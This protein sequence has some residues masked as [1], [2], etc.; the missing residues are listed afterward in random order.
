MNAYMR[1]W[2]VACSLVLGGWASAGPLSDQVSGVEVTL[3]TSM[4]SIEI[5]LDSNRAPASTA[6]F[7]AI[8]DSGELARDGTFFRTVRK[9]ENDHGHPPIDVIEGGL[10]HPATNLPT[11]GHES[12]QETGLRHLD[13]TVSLARRA[14]GNIT[15]AAF[16]I[17]I[18][19]QPALDLGGGRD[20][21]GDGQ[22]FAA[23][24]RVTRGMEI[25]RAIHQQAVSESSDDP[26]MSGQILDPPIRILRTFRNTPAPSGANSN[27]VPGTRFRDCPTCPEMIVIPSG[28]FTM[29]RKTAADG[30]KDDDPEGERKSAPPREVSIGRPFAAGVFDV[31]QA[32]YRVFVQE[33]GRRDMDGCYIWTYNQ[34]R[35]DPGKDWSNPGFKQTEHDPVVCINWPDAQAYVSWLNDRVRGARTVPDGINDRPYRLLSWEEAEYAAAGG[36]SSLYYWGPMRSRQAANYGADRCFPCRGAT[37]AADRWLYTSPVGSFAANAYGLYDMAGNVWQWTDGCYPHRDHPPTA[38]CRYGIV[39]GGSWLS[40]PEYLQTG[41]YG[42]LVRMNRNF[43]TGFRVARSL[44]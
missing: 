35:S 7:L 29:T 41:E 34:W 40:N 15:A 13:G 21:Y 25:V 4:G 3:E 16:F 14:L 18:G 44:D 10:Q 36:A 11:I 9:S 5:A 33:T 30:R 19:D 17:C 24:G 31:T 26:Y 32:E 27:R 38:E 39:R 8:V 20:P 42:V 6:A 1:G 28:T 23:F 2:V 37:A 43:A 22:G 12:T